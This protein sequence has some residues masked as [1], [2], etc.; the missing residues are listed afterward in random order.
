MASLKTYTK[1]TILGW[2]FSVKHWLTKDMGWGLHVHSIVQKRPQKFSHL[3]VYGSILHVE[4]AEYSL[5]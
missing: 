5:V 2:W 1:K 4:V 3:I